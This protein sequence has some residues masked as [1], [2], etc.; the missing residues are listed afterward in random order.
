MV[1]AKSSVGDHKDALGKLD[2]AATALLAPIAP[3]PAPASPIAT[4][5]VAA[6]QGATEH[7]TIATSAQP[8][9]LAPDTKVSAR[10]AA[11][12]SDLAFSATLTPKTSSAA[13]SDSTADPRQQ[14]NAANDA[15]PVV[16]QSKSKTSVHSG[17]EEPAPPA[18]LA[19]SLPAQT[20]NSIATLAP[21][22]AASALKA[23]EAPP[24]IEIATALRTTEPVVAIAPAPRVE[25][26]QEI[27]V[28]I[29]R[30][31]MP[32]V[33]L[34]IAERGGQIH[35]AV[36][37][38]DGPLQTSLRQ[39]VGSLVDSLDRA[40]YHAETFA[41]IA[42]SMHSGSSQMGNRDSQP[43]TQPDSSGHG[44]SDSG[45]SRQQQS[46][47]RQRDPR[48]QKFNYEMESAE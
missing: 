46:Q 13:T 44:S 39:D 7:P 38:P 23:P 42:A 28:R 26:A 41:P 45:A 15:A 9:P 43:D 48:S 40:G 31:Q 1:P 25:A 17:D 4:S 16:A 33:D 8:A 5:P 10:A 36:H 6:A 37:T 24:R 14:G 11:P 22:A 2:A 30:P 29:E 3:L 19:Q 47:Q 27:A 12:N 34:R 21:L 32:P 18:S 20:L 35:V